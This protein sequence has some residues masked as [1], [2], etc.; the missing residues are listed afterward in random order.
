MPTILFY[1]VEATG[2][3][4]KR[5]RS[6]TR[7]GLNAKT[8][9][10]YVFSSVQFSSQAS[11]CDTLFVCF[12]ACARTHASRTRGTLRPQWPSSTFASAK[13]SLTFYRKQNS[14]IFVTSELT[15]KYIVKDGVGYTANGVA[16]RRIDILL[17]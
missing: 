1:G 15:H 10:N 7:I 14:P 8:R 4:G 12:Q 6:E 17:S 2:R 3:K 16:A 5:E 9:I 11:C 13:L